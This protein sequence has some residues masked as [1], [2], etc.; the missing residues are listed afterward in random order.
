MATPT[1]R[2]TELT[3]AMALARQLVAYCSGSH[4]V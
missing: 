1:K 2:P 3:K 4:S